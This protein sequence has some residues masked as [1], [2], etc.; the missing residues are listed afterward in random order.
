MDEQEIHW[1]LRWLMDDFGSKVGQLEPIFVQISA[2]NPNQHDLH[3]PNESQTTIDYHH[4]DV[5]RDDGMDE[6][7]IHWHLRWLMDDFGSKIWQLLEPAFL[8]KSQPQIQTSMTSMGQMMNPKQPLII[9]IW[10]YQEMMVWMSR[11]ST[12]I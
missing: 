2:T 8:F 1:H 3:G 7:E 4:R 12:G 6:Q 11:K 10:M 9:I 5:L